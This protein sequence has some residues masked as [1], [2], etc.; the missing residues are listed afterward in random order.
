MDVKSSQMTFDATW[1]PL[2]HV[3][4]RD[5]QLRRKVVEGL[6][7]QGWAVVDAE[8]GHH[9]LLNLSGFLMD[10]EPWW[11]PKLVVV[12]VIS[13][14]CLGTT[15]AE[16]LRDLGL[17]V[18]TVLVQGDHDLDGRVREEPENGIIVA[19]DPSIALATVLEVARYCLEDG[20]GVGPANDNENRS[21][22][23]CLSEECDV[24]DISGPYFQT[25][26]R[27]SA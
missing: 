10:L 1:R 12:D 7:A 20:G 8:S 24:I 18:T 5:D 2:A 3:A 23:V 4:L 6:R 22:E 27:P 11:P 21:K 15:I 17:P 19:D 14:G 16:G 25:V 9:L 13:P 26:R